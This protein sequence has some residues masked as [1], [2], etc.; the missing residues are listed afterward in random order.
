MKGAA[1]K[2][3]TT[4]AEMRKMRL[5]DNLSFNTSYDMFRDSLRWSNINISGRT[6]LLKKINI[7]VNSSFSPYSYNEFGQTINRSMF[8]DRGKILRFTNGN[9]AIGGSI[10]S[11]NRTSNREN[12]SRGS[13]EEMEM[14]ENNPQ[15]FV[16]WNVP[17]T[18]NFNYTLSANRTFFQQQGELVDSLI[19]QQSVMF[20][21]DITL[22]Q[23]WK[24][25]VNTGFDF[26]TKEPTTTTV[27]LYWD[28]HCWELQASVVPF[29]VRKSYQ[30]H[31]NIKAS[32][33]QDLKLQRRGNLG[34][35]QNFF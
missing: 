29:G 3:D 21:G 14:I 10:Q 28:L 5:I 17:W 30:V 16:D 22:F 4:G 27:T 15:M 35:N 24:L 18:M 2:S 33:L 20:N 25:G 32:I 7:N 23:K 26:V 34:S 12:T 31:V 8:E 11:Q 1:A 19:I 9:L 13:E 6:T